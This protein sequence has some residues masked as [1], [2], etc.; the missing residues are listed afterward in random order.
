MTAQP[1]RP[2]IK[3]TFK[4]TILIKVTNP[5]TWDKWQ[6]FAA[7]KRNYGVAIEELLDINEKYQLQ[8]EK[9]SQ[10]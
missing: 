9:N 2:A 7:R 6:K 4:K 8:F 1:G 3:I 5:E 10:L